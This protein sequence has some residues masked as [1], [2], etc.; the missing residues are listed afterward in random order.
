[1]YLIV[2]ISNG[3]TLNRKMKSFANAI[4]NG[5]ITANIETTVFYNNNGPGVVTEQWNGGGALYNGIIYNCIIL[6]IG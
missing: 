1:M 5:H 2:C 4:K 6:Y 3:I